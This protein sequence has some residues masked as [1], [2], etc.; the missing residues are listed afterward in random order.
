MSSLDKPTIW[1]IGYSLPIIVLANSL[2]SSIILLGKPD[3][4][5]EAIG[6]CDA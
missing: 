1:M 6:L 5:L 4:T 2:S 3:D